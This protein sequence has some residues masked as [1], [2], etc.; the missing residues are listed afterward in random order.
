MDGGSFAE[1]EDR[2]AK[3]EGHVGI[4]CKQ[5]GGPGKEYYHNADYVFPSASTFKVFILAEIMRRACQGQINLEDTYTLKNDDWCPGSGVLREL[6]PGT[7]ISLYDLC[8]FMIII[9]D[10]SATD[11][12]L[13]IAGI[14]NVAKLL[15]RAGCQQTSVPMGCKG[16][17]AHFAGI[18]VKWPTHQQCMEATE[19]IRRGAVDDQG[20]AFAGSTENVVTT[21]RD[22][23]R[24][25]EQLS[26]HRNVFSECTSRRS[27]S[28][29]KR[30]RLSQR[31]PSRLPADVVVAH[32][33]GTLRG[34]KVAVHN[35]AGIVYPDGNVPYVLSIYT[36]IRSGSE[37]GDELVA[38]LSQLL[39]RLMT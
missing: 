34:P 4:A 36:A 38:E 15:E 19:R 22:M 27:I 5:L 33:T 35:D 25:L 8:V 20:L 39:Y 17:L 10:N 6:T 3:V 26:S 31:I 11:I 18:P 29:L 32:K 30:Q 16:I 23:S 24:F 28:V 37:D 7:G 21:A 12:C 14:D 2:I 13:E 9:S 1:V